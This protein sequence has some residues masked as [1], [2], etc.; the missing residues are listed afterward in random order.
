MAW[1]TSDHMATTA[2]TAAQTCAIQA[3]C[4]TRFFGGD[5]ATDETQ[6]ARDLLRHVNLLYREGRLTADFLRIAF[7]ALAKSTRVD[8]Q[9]LAAMDGAVACVAA[10]ERQSR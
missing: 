4:E 1:G 5:G 10:R 8:A 2:V 6:L 7:D 9:L 3:E